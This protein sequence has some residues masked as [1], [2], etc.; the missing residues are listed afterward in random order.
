MFLASNKAKNIVLEEVKVG[1]DMG[2]PALTGA[3]IKQHL[4][5]QADIIRNLI[6]VGAKELNISRSKTVSV[7]SVLQR[8][9]DE[10]L[11]FTSNKLNWQKIGG[12]TNVTRSSLNC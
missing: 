9:V 8:N 1:Y 5:Q 10:Q 6:S 3:E 4:D 7:I 12:V 11:L 2:K